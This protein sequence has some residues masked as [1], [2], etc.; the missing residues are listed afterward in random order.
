MAF[1][2]VPMVVVTLLGPQYNVG[3]KPTVILYTYIHRH[4]NRF[5]FLIEGLNAPSANSA[6]LGKTWGSEI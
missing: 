5:G 6:N 3:E 1:K 4:V 2:R